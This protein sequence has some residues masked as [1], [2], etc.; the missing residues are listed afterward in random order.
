[1]NFLE[2]TTKERVLREATRK[3]I[4]LGKKVLS[5]DHDYAMEVV[6]KRKL[7]DAAKRILKEKGVWFQTPFTRM[8]IHWETGT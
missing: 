7:Y 3:K 1:M 6:Q 8:S 4:Q 5:F 2:F